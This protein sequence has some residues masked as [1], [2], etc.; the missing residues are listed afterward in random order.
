[1]RAAVLR[2][3]RFC[4]GREYIR[5]VR[6]GAR[7]ERCRLKHQGNELRRT[8]AGAAAIW[9]RF[10]NRHPSAT[11][12]PCDVGSPS[13][14]ERCARWS[15]TQVK[16][17]TTAAHERRMRKTR[18]RP[19]EMLRSGATRIW[20]DHLRTSAQTVGEISVPQTRLLDI[21]GFS[22]DHQPLT[23][24]GSVTSPGQHPGKRYGAG[25]I[26]EA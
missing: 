7:V 24:K 10:V 14:G 5:C 17:S 11:R 3:R 6:H 26:R 22:R 23:F 8:R 15:Q 2:C 13:C 12:S 9:N 1:M 4:R 19:G 20:S 25:S 16:Q 21:Q 18:A